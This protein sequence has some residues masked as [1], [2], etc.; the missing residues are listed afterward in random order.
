MPAD[1]NDELMAR[2]Q[3]GD[4]TAIA[5]IDGRFGTELRAFC[6]RMVYNEMLAEDIVQDVLVTCCRSDGATRPTGSL[7]GWLYKVARNKS[8]DELRRMHPKA[9]LS[10]L[11]SSRQI[12][13]SSAV[14]IDPLTTPAGRAV[15]QDR[16]R[17]VQL[18]IDAME[19]DL[20]EVVIMYFFQGLS[21]AEV[22]EAIGLSLSGTKARIAKATRLLREK[23]RALDDSSL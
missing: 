13:M 16:T 20:R 1:P 14:P 11:Q 18:A 6:Q 15:K 5:E 12:W 8:I 23:L 3:G 10:A 19:D 7:R 4:S 21:R 9:R 17:R 2:L 22:S